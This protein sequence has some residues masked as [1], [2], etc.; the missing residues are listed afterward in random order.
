[1]WFSFKFMVTDR[2]WSWD[3]LKIEYSL[4]T[5]TAFSQPNPFQYSDV[6]GL[7]LEVQLSSENL[8]YAHASILCDSFQ[9]FPT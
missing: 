3:L 4:R 5:H 8:A 9:T 6:L 1:M 2:R 7:G